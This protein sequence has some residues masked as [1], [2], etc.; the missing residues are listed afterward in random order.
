MN[1]RYNDTGSVFTSK[2]SAIVITEVVV[3]YSRIVH[4]RV[5]HWHVL[6]CTVTGCM[7]RTRAY[8]RI[9]PVT[10]SRRGVLRSSQIVLVVETTL[11][12]FP[13]R[14]WFCVGTLPRLNLSTSTHHPLTSVLTGSSS[15]RS[16]PRSNAHPSTCGG[17][18]HACH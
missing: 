10:P 14:S 6:A 9:L 11:C 16:Y 8:F 3:F 13:S 2:H 15:L 17:G 4:A 1:V 12:H 5:A 18:V 7:L